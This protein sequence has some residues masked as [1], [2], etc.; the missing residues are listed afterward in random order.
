[1]LD[2][3]LEP[4]Q[5]AEDNLVEW[6]DGARAL[7][8]AAVASIEIVADAETSPAVLAWLQSAANWLTIQLV[9]ENACIEPG[10]TF[11]AEDDN[12]VTVGIYEAPKEVGGFAVLVEG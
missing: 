3:A 9:A 10:R 4:A 12:N 7:L 8:N 5:P 6:D 1:M 11:A 2:T